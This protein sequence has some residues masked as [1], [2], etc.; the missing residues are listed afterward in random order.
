M[1]YFTA[2]VRLLEHRGRAS[3]ASCSELRFVLALLVETSRRR[4]STNSAST[5]L[6][7]LQLAADALPLCSSNLTWAVKYFMSDRLTAARSHS[8]TSNFYGQSLTR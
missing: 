8:S 1:K 4:V 6:S 7:S 2:Q 3:A 5:N